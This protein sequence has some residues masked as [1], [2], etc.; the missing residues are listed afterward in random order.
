MAWNPLDALPGWALAL[1]TYTAVALVAARWGLRDRGAPAGAW[2]D[3]LGDLR[4]RLVISAGA[5]AGTALLLFSIRWDGILRLAVHESLAAQAFSLM[6]AD[7]LPASVQLVVVRPIDGFL[8]Q[9]TLA[10]GLAA[11]ITAPVW[12]TQIAGFI[13]PALRPLE[14]RVVRNAIAPVIVLFGLGAAFAYVYV[15]PFLLRTLYGYGAALDAQPLLQVSEF[16]GF[17]VGLM[18]VMGLAFQTPIVMYSLTSIELVPANAWLKGWRVATIVILVMSALV[19][20]PTVVSQLM[21]AAPL[22]LLYFIGVAACHTVRPT[23]R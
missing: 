13:T 5:L 2:L 3:H 21:V 18:A 4:K 22:M 16:I 12:V 10:F 6:Q 19:T 15:I 8:A 20:D 23:S 1:L 7:L 9:M 14:K 11:L 17:T